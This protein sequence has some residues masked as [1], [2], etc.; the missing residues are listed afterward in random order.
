VAVTKIAS[1]IAKKRLADIAKKKIAKVPTKEAR[2]VAVES[3]KIKAGGTRPLMRPKGMGNATTRSTNIP[4][5]TTV[6]SIPKKSPEQTSKERA[7]SKSLQRE[8]FWTGMK[9]LPKVK[10]K[11]TNV[12]HNR[13]RT[14][15]QQNAAGRQVNKFI[16]KQARL[17]QEIERKSYSIGKKPTEPKSLNRSIFEREMNIPAGSGSQLRKKLAVEQFRAEVRAKQVGKSEWQRQ[18]RDS[19]LNP[20]SPTVK[21][22][23]SKIDKLGNKRVMHPSKTEKSWESDRNAAK[24]VKE[25]ERLTE[26]NKTRK[27]TTGG[28]RP[29]RKPR[30]K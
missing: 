9:N 17:R 23:S 13:P 12:L 19:I 25:S 14:L 20:A 5:K 3:Q 16:K 11:P 29:A 8:D 2:K 30:G 15:R 24:A 6:K 22:I 18:V 10:P 1:I 21:G 4:R 7:I 28:G 26:K 27:Y